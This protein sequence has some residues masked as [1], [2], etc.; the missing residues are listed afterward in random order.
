MGTLLSHDNMKILREQF[1][2]L[3]FFFKYDTGHPPFY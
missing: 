1:S 2:E 3:D